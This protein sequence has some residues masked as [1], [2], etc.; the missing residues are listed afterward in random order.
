MNNIKIGITGLPQAGKTQTLMKVIEMLESEGLKVGGMITEPI[1]DDKRRS[2]FYVIDWRTKEKG[3]LAST[4]IKSKF[5]VGKFGIDLEVLEEIGVNALNKACEESDVIVIDEVGKIEVESEKF[6]N[7]VK[8]ALDVEKPILL[9]LHKKS[10]N[11]LLQDIRRRD[12][13]R[14]L[15]VTPINR[16]LLPYKIMKL[17]KGELL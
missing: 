17:M 3:I 11:P 2:G 5:M 12:D 14:I 13:V 10:R 8:A 15:E 4:E 7:A 1:L 9:T 6:V 16:N